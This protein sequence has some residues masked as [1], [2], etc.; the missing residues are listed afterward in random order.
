MFLGSNTTDFTPPQNTQILDR[1]KHYLLKSLL[2]YIPL[3]IVSACA[4]PK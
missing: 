2:L 3:F 4:D 1:Y